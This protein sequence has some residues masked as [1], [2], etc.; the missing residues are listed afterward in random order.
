M[1]RVESLPALR[2]SGVPHKRVDGRL[3]VTGAAQ[4]AADFTANGLTYGFVVRAR[5]RRGVSCRLIRR[6]RLRCRACCM[7]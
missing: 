3:K 2:A 5:S 7:C 1:N 6:P 4:Y